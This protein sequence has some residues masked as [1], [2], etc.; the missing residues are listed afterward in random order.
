MF[1]AHA[2]QL[3]AGNEGLEFGD[4]AGLEHGA[5]FLEVGTDAEWFGILPDYHRLEA[6]LGFAH[7]AVHA[8]EHAGTDG[9][10]LRSEEHTSELQSPVHLVCRLLLEKKK[11]NKIR[12]SASPFYSAR[13]ITPRVYLGFRLRNHP[14][15]RTGLCFPSCTT[16]ARCTTLYWR[17][18]ACR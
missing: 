2:G 8:V 13:N 4:L 5:G 6:A 18:C 10:H 14:Y 7:G 12:I 9:V 11:N 1:D 3:E 15:A 16:S 17:R